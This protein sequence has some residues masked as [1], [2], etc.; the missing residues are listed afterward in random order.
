MSETAAHVVS[1]FEREGRMRPVDSASTVER[2]FDRL[3]AIRRALEAAGVEFIDD[4]AGP[5][6]KLW[7]PDP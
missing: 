7:K 1:A 2:S 5:N 6:V 4:G 3:T